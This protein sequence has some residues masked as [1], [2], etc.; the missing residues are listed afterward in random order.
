MLQHDSTV[1]GVHEAPPENPISGLP[2]GRNWSRPRRP[3]QRWPRRNK[4]SLIVSAVILC[5]ALAGV[6][7]ANA[8]PLND[9]VLSPGLAQP[10]GPL[11]SVPSHPA[12][13]SH[14]QI[15]LTDVYE[16]PLSAL[17]W[18]FYELDS[19]DAVYSSAALF[20]PS[21]SPTQ[22]QTGEVLQ[23]VGSSQLARVVALRQLGY[24]VPERSGAVVEQVMAG[25]PAAGLGNLE[26]GDAVTAVDGKSTPSAASLVALLGKDHPGQRIVLSVIH[27]DGAKANESL[28]LAARAGHTSEA[29]AG[30]GVVTGAYFALPFEVNINSDGIEGPSAGL[31]FTLGIMNELSGGDL[32][33]GLKVAATG[34]VALGGAV[35]PVGGVAQKTIAVE[36]AGATVFLVPNSDGNYRQALSKA[37]SHL[38]VI[39]VNTLAQALVALKSLG[40]SVAITGSGMP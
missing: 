10:V 31:A 19:N 36:N 26:P 22:A 33:G 20:G 5:V 30:V 4:R 32:A 17:Q 35:G 29:Y 39:P 24:A 16:A 13:P 2:P 25:T 27:V 12:P 38:R 21:V 3:R 34:T 14:G 9:Y 7:I 18:P 23:M 6:F 28:T 11:I 8:I 15:L 37:N 1:Q 40:G